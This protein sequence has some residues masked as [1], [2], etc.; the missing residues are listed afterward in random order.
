MRQSHPVT[1]ERN[2]LEL[3]DTPAIPALRR[4]RQEDHRCVASLGYTERHWKK[5]E[6]GG[7][8]EEEREKR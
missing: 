8:E 1:Q 3:Y 7:E 2:S 6:D 5:G 4:L